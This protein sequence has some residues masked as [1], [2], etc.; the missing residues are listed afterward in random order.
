MARQSKKE[1]SLEEAKHRLRGAAKHADQDALYWGEEH[2]LEALSTALIGGYML[3]RYPALR[4][5]L[6]RFL[7]YYSQTR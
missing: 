6:A 1:M 4:H 3:A 5:L 2:L 7:V